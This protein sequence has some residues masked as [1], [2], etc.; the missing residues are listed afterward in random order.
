MTMVVGGI[1]PAG[2][3]IL[4]NSVAGVALIRSMLL[5]GIRP[6]LG[7]AYS[8]FSFLQFLSSL[9]LFFLHLIVEGGLCLRCSVLTC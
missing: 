7:K 8:C 3:L 4:V 6:E 1:V 9:P 2:F 5:A